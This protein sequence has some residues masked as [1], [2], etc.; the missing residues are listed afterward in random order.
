MAICLIIVHFI[1]KRT[2]FCMTW[3]VNLHAQYS[4]HAQK[5]LA[6]MSSK[7]HFL[8]LSQRCDL[9]TLSYVHFVLFDKNIFQRNG[10]FKILEYFIRINS[11]L[12]FLK[13]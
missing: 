13:E 8:S 10:I 6:Q 9:G 4:K 3:R 7:S 11:R 1:T 5:K 12:R 2:N